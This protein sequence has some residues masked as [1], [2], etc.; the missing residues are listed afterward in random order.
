MLSK[1]SSKS[2]DL[3]SKVYK[4]CKT[5]LVSYC[6]YLRRPSNDRIIAFKFTDIKC[7]DPWYSVL[8]TTYIFKWFFQDN[9]VR[10]DNLELKMLEVNYMFM[11]VFCKISGKARNNYD[12]IDQLF[13]PSIPCDISRS[14]RIVHIRVPIFLENICSP[15]TLTLIHPQPS[16]SMQFWSAMI[17]SLKVWTLPVPFLFKSL[18]NDHRSYVSNIS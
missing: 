15:F 16:R 9:E 11:H 10:M 14:Q 18:Y 12:C 1:W 5:I 4:F 2:I 17:Y 6:L 8:D 13:P 7:I 3:C